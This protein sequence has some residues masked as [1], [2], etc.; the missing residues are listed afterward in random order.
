LSAENFI[1]YF[2]SLMV[3][4]F[5]GFSM[6]KFMTM[7]F[8]KTT[9][10]ETN[11]TLHFSSQAFIQTLIVFSVIYILIMGMNYAFIKRQTVLTLFKVAS[12][13][14]SRVKK[15]SF[16]EIAIGVKG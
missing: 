14:E 10:I 11:A 8:F 2:S 7:I 5:L 1:L 13:T 6:S 16:F 3:G 15:I 12:S 9:G 4:I